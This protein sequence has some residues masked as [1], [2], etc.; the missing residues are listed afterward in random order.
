MNAGDTV[1]VLAPFA[2]AFPGTY[3]VASVD[4]STAFLDGV[5]DALS[6][7]FDFAYLERVP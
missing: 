5:G 1:R 7:A 4:G 6:N 3:L 2:D